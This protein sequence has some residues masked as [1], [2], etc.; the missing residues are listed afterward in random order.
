[1]Q[2]NY[3]NPSFYNDYQYFTPYPELNN[4]VYPSG[5]PAANAPGY[6]GEPTL[7]PYMPMNRMYSDY[8][9]IYRMYPAAASLIQREA[10]NEADRLDYEGGIIYDVYPDKELLLRHTDMIYSRLREQLMNIM[11]PC[12]ET[13]AQC[14]YPDDQY[15]A[16]RPWVMC[17]IQVI[18]YNEIYR[19]RSKRG[20][21]TPP[22][23]EPFYRGMNRVMPPV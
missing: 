8:G 13:E 18:F 2:D 23:Y 19:R 7:S 16:D 20:Y 15:T 6:V 5:M 11:R 10:E 9:Y 3:R 22:Y 12:E 1:M 4:P 14:E 21:N 17:L